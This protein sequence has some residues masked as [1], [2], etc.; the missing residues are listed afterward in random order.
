MPRHPCKLE[1]LSPGL[2]RGSLHSP[3][4]EGHRAPGVD[5]PMGSSLRTLGAGCGQPF[6]LL[7]HLPR[8]PGE[9]RRPGC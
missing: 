5:R 8:G 1:S 6:F 4:L 2:G 7:R 3:A 9:K